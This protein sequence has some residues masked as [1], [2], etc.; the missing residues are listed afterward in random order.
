MEQFTFL[1]QTGPAVCAR[2]CCVHVGVRVLCVPQCGPIVR[3]F[4]PMG[5]NCVRSILL[6]KWIQ[7]ES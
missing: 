5:A 7:I 6:R 3:K 1:L 4:F 2:P